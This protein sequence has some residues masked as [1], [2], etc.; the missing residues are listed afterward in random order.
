[1]FTEIVPVR[2]YCPGVIFTSAPTTLKS[3]PIRRI[4]YKI[5]YQNLT[6]CQ[7]SIL[8]SDSL[9]SSLGSLLDHLLV[10]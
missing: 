1:M 8:L 3:D 10:F 5:P 9:Q 7:L 2:T 6:Q 4:K